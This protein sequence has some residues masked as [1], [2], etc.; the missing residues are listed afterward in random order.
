MIFQLF[1]TSLC[2][3]PS[4]SLSLLSLHTLPALLSGTDVSGCLDSSQRWY[5]FANLG[6]S[7]V[8]SLIYIFNINYCTYKNIQLLTKGKGR[9]RELV[10]R[11]G[12]MIWY[13]VRGKD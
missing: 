2:I 5:E 11:E 4:A 12:N 8:L 6:S 10:G 13:W 7:Q 1:Y 9:E 3:H